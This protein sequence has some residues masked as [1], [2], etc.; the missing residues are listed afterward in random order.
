MSLTDT[1]LQF[2]EHKLTKDSRSRHYMMKQLQISLTISKDRFKHR[3][4]LQLTLFIV[5]ICSSESRDA[6]FLSSCKI[7]PS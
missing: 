1:L 3:T 7:F 5:P 2:I 4:S 6:L